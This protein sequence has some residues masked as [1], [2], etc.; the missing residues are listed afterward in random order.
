AL[1]S[2]QLLATFTDPGGADHLSNYTAT[3]DWGDSS[4]ATNVPVSL[5]ATPSLS[6]ASHQPVGQWPVTVAAA[7]FNGDGKPDLVTASAFDG[8]VKIAQ[9]NGD[10]TFQ[11]PQ[12][13]AL[14]ARPAWLAVGDLNGDGKPDVVTANPGADTISVLLNNGLGSLWAPS[15]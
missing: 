1:L 14:G 2:N 5:A 4:P 12:S 6:F 3:V 7:D 10:G 13:Y 11:L 15:I 8:S 9:G